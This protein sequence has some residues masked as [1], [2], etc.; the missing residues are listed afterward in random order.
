MAPSPARAPRGAT[1]RELLSGAAA[2]ATLALGGCRLGPAVRPS[3]GRA[4][5]RLARAAIDPARV[6]RTVVGLRPFRPGGF[7][8]GARKLGDKL[9]V[10]DY[11]HGGCGV[12]LSWGTGELAAAEALQAG[13]RSAAVI[14]AG[15]VGLAAAR[16]LQERGLEVTIYARELPPHTTSNVA[17]AQWF[18]ASSSEAALRTPGF[19]A[20]LSVAARFAW[21]R[22]ER[23]I[24]PRYGVRRVANYFLSHHPFDE[25]EL[26]GR[27]GPLAGIVPP[28]VDLPPE[29]NPFDAPFVRRIDTLFIETPI[30]LAALLDELRGAGA[31]IAQREL[32]SLDEI[33]ALPEPVVVNC[34]GLGARALVG[35]VTLVPLKGQLAV[36]PPQPA[37]DYNVLAGDLYAFPRTD[38]L[39]LGG[40]FQR[41]VEDLSPDP[42]EAARILDGNAR[43][44]AAM[45]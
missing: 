36:L 31:R 14:G 11:G 7:V 38:G 35:D 13:S 27:E 42:D 20:Q 39:L 6:V 41:G 32:R 15:A 43:L 26:A 8:V 45:R 5:L 25:R 9:L 30:Y 18:P 17:G 44:F 29:E 34:T 40:S 3:S 10:D 2:A 33:A 23:M 4:R 37:L 24:G 16:L 19:V 28:P 21:C 1:R 12:T 22:F